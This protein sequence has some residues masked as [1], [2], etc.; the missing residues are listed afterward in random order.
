MEKKD[1]KLMSNNELQIYMKT[2]ENEFEAMKIKIQ[3]MCDELKEIDKEY[4]RAK[5]ELGIRQGNIY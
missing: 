2:L 1:T 5:N 4:G 3:N